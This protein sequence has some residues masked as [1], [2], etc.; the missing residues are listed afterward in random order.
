MA[1]VARR[2]ADRSR[3]REERDRQRGRTPGTRVGTARGPCGARLRGDGAADA[4]PRHRRRAASTAR[5]HRRG[6]RRGGTHAAAGRGRGIPPRCES[7]R[8]RH[9]A[10][11]CLARPA[12]RSHAGGRHGGGASHRLGP[13][14]LEVGAGREAARP[15]RTLEGAC[16]VVERRARCPGRRDLP[17]GR[18]R[19]ARFRRAPGRRRAA[20]ARAQGRRQ[21]C[22]RL[23]E[24]GAP[25]RRRSGSAAT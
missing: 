20:P 5:A 11:V 4:S 9:R 19:R 6:G 12:D 2:L 18:G 14:A 7:H 3:R 25:R 8:F 23:A 21:R 15:D 22:G 24:V 10:G 17:G 16:A 13:H 1:R